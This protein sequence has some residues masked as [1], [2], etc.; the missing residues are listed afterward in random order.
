M[1]IKIKNSGSYVSNFNG[2]PI[3]NKKYSLDV[4]SD[5]NK[6]KQVLGMVYNNGNIEGIQDTLQNYMR[7]ISYNNRSIFDLLRQEHNEVNKIPNIAVKITKAPIMRKK[8]NNATLIDKQK[9]RKNNKGIS[10]KLFDFTN[11]NTISDQSPIQNI[12]PINV[13]AQKKHT[14]KKR[15]KLSTRR[16]RRTRR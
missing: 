11:L 14:Y 10:S 7:K 4:D 5:R 2:I 1:T 15:R 3:I 8:N 16:K 13:P 6:D 12:N 9:T